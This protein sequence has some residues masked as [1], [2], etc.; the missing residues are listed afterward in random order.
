MPA[1]VGGQVAA[2]SVQL[3]NGDAAAFVVNNVRPGQMPSGDAAL[4]AQFAEQAAG[5]AGMA[6]FAAY[7][8]EVE[9]NAKIVR[10]S[11]VFDQ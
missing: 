3:A 6:E 2:G 10:N 5:Q 1:P 7:V 4:M 8:S 11:K 9:R